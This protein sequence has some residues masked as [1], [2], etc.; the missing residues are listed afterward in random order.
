[1]GALIEPK[2]L[3]L[4]AYEGMNA[5]HLREL[6]ILNRLYSALGGEA[7]DSEVEKLF[8]EF[9]EDVENH[10]S[11]EEELMKLTY[12]FAFDC[13]HGEHNRVRQELK[14]VFNRWLKT[15][16]RKAAL[17]Y[18]EST[19]KPWIVEH[20]NTMDTVTAQ[21]VAKSLFNIGGALPG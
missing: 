15:K 21:W 14:E 17:N 13:H 20:I 10:F 9:I 12:F 8:R 3:P 2:D 6:G 16:D 1:M 11:Y 18:F 19:F 4:T 7:D 5:V